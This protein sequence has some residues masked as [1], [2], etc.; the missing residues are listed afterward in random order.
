MCCIL[1]N[2]QKKSYFARIFITNEPDN[3]IGSVDLLI[4]SRK[5]IYKTEITL[6][7]SNKTHGTHDD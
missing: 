6:S 4:L 7:Y 2:L 5:W 1:F 3:L